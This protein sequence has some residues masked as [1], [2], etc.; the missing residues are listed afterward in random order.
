[1][2]FENVLAGHPLLDLA[3]THCYAQE[4]RS[5]ATLTALVDG[6]GNM[7]EDWREALD[8]YVLYHWLE[9]WDWFAHLGMNDPLA[10]LSRDMRQLV[11][12]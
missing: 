7:P 6:H 3:K 8:L 9:L 11:A 5:E 12:A 4:R 2:D 1:V 10:G